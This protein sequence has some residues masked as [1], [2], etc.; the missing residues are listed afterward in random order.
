MMHSSRQD[1][2]EGPGLRRALG[3]PLLFLYGIGTLVGGGFYALLGAVTAQ[4]G[5]AL[6][7]A[8][9][10]A[11]LL[12]L[13]S[14]LSYS[15][16]A[17]RFPVSAG[18]ARYVDAAFGRRWAGLLVGVLVIATG[19]VSSATLARAVGGF[20]EELIGLATVVGAVGVIVFLT[21][22]ASVG[23]KLS[24]LFAV[25]IT[26]IEV[27]G[28]LALLFL[29]RDAWPQLFDQGLGAVMPTNLDGG[30]GLLG[31]AFIA[32]YAYIGFEDLVNMAEEAKDPART[33]PR[34]VLGSLLATAVLYV[35]VCSLAVVAVTP[36]ELAASRS[37]L[38][39]LAGGGT[40]GDVLTAIGVLAG[41]NGALVQV[42]MGS[43]VLYGLAPKDNVLRLFRRISPR[44]GT[45]VL[46]TLAVG[47]LAAVAAFAGS[48]GILAE[49]TSSVLLSVFVT[50][51]C[52]LIVIQKRA[53]APDHAPD[54]PHWVPWVGALASAGVLTLRLAL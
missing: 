9:L 44:T 19:I 2:D 26:V 43:R 38:A 54:V 53:P 14:A 10:C 37:P 24:T 42:V 33:I 18:E 30:I 8:F 36:A 3:L 7:L 27:G 51:N 45:P 22:I 32:F 52:A 40:A 35:S 50:V 48:L 13:P 15:A 46:A 1:R 25:G 29:R 39:T 5:Q 11:G 31:G 28:I 12:A 34:A 41:L 20:L 4:A 47:T 21:L 23:V 49:I 6:P 17:A 16:L